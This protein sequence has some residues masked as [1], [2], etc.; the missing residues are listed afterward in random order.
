V[1]KLTAKMIADARRKA[2]GKRGLLHIPTRYLGFIPGYP[3]IRYSLCGLHSDYQK[4]SLAGSHEAPE[5][6]KCI[7]AQAKM[8][9]TD[10]DN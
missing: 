5:C 8:E 3:F 2:E 1:A 9:A 7:A 10:R 6:K 4:F